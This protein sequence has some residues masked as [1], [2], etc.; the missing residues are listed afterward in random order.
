MKMIICWFKFKKKQGVDDIAYYH[1]PW[2]FQIVY[3]MEW[4]FSHFVWWCCVCGLVCSLVPCLGKIGNENEN[5]EKGEN[6]EINIFSIFV[7]A[8]LLFRCACGCR[9]SRL[10]Y[11]ISYFI[12]WSLQLSQVDQ[13]NIIVIH[14]DNHHHHWT[15]RDNI[16]FTFQILLCFYKRATKKW[17]SSYYAIISR[18]S[19]WSK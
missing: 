18:Y 17:W 3:W 15:Y 7:Y 5:G 1:L 11:N 9:W 19:G 16:I 6:R 4:V 10:P 12:P 8:H 2:T 14:D 13:Q